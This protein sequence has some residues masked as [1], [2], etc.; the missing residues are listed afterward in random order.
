MIGDIVPNS[1]TIADIGTDHALLPIYLIKKNKSKNI[2]A[3]DIN[4]KPL[5]IAKKN[6]EKNHLTPNIRILKGDGINPLKNIQ[7]ETI[8]ISGLGPDTI[9][10][11][12][13][14]INNYKYKNTLKNIIIC[15]NKGY[16]KI[17]KYLIK[18]KFLIKNEMIL[19]ENNK[20]Y[21]IIFFKKGKKSYNKNDKIFGPILRK[22]K[23]QIF[24]KK[25]TKIYNKNKEILKNIKQ[26]NIFKK[27]KIIILNKR[28]KK[29]IKKL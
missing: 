13:K 17:R 20:I 19:E 26:S 18:K 5:Q 28:I 9:L 7:I 12:L 29:T 21:E 24:I 2:Y 15:A 16:K 6:V 23:N 25:W 11:I 8:V 27:I 10:K 14:D 1:K 22:E 4:D 3:T